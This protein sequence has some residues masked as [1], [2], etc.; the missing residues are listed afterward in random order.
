MLRT[1]VIIT[2]D[3]NAVVAPIRNRMP[4]VIEEADWSARL[5]EFE[6][7]YAALLHPVSTGYHN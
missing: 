5:G 6:G 2:T 1:F 3:A 7:E 4:A